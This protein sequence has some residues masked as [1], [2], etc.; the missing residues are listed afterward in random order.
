[1]THLN[2]QELVGALDGPLDGGRSVHLEGCADCQREV[3]ELRAIMS[4]VAATA[5][6]P[7]PSPLFWDHFS[8]RVSGAVSAEVVPAARAWWQLG[9]R[10]MTTVAVVSACVM[11]AVAIRLHDRVAPT[12][13]ATMAAVTMPA[14]GDASSVDE[15]NASDDASADVVAAVVGGGISWDQA[16]AANLVPGGYTVETAVAA[17]TDAQQRE[18]IRLVREAMNDGVE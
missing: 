9:W 6:V 13:E 4:T 10:S 1:M 17:L 16:R 14:A 11:L 5:D 18:L 8:A 3:G 2:P 7:E 12:P 15:L